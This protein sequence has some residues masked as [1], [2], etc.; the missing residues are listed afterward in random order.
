MYINLY[1]CRALLIEDSND[2]KIQEVVVNSSILGEV[3]I[4]LPWIS[5]DYRQVQR[6]EI[7]KIF[8]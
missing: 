4:T 7:E 2:L 3:G 5:R 8:F 6:T 1:Q